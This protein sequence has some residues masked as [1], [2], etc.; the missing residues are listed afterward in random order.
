VYSCLIITP[1]SPSFDLL[2]TVTQ[3]R[4]SPLHSGRSA[5]AEPQP[6]GKRLVEGARRHQ[7]L[8]RIGLG[9]VVI[10]AFCLGALLLYRGQQRNQGLL[11]LQ[12]GIQLLQGG[13]PQDAVSY[14]ERAARRLP[15]GEAQRLARLYLGRAYAEQQPETAQQIYEEF[16]STVEGGDYL[17]QLALIDLGQKAERL[18]DFP[19]AHQLYADA[20][21]L[22][23]PMKGEALLAMARAFEGMKDSSSAQASYT[24]FLDQYPDSPLTEVI[25]QKVGQ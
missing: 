13:N 16:L 19:R 4:K 2:F 6:F 8:L 20:A 15:D 5:L 22:D 24:K 14:F 3:T 12:K 7:R 1:T 18:G 21:D 17:K 9:G 11:E 25:R 10:L 23:G